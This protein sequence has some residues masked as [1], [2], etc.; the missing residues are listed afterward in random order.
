MG[1]WGFDRLSVIK[2]DPGRWTG[3]ID[4]GPWAPTYGHFYSNSPYKNEEPPADHPIR[5]IWDLWD[6]VQVEP[7]EAT[8]NAL[9]QQLLNVHKAAPY[10]IGVGGEV[11][12]PMVASIS[13][14]NVMEGFIADDTLRDSGLINPQQFFIV[15]S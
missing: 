13:F 6:R 1:N 8:R 9:F 12:S 7:D 10:A 5:Q 2:A 4:D 11:I 15:R 14:R 3:T